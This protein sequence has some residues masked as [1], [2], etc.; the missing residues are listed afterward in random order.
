L[1]IVVA[2]AA[3]AVALVGAARSAGYPSK[4]GCAVAWNRTAPAALRSSIA[5]DHPRG[6]FVNGAVSAG[7]VTWTKGGKSTSTSGPGCGIQFILASG[8]TLAVWGTWRDGRVPK[9]SGPVTSARPIPVPNNSNVHP[10][11]TVGFHG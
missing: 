6:A 8:R 5:G 1:A 3:H 10:D 4:S 7:T 11:G 9:W 2:V